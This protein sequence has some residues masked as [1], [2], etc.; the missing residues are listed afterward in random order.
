MCYNTYFLFSVTIILQTGGGAGGENGAKNEWNAGWMK[1]AGT[2]GTE[3]VFL[4]PGGWI[5]PAY[6]VP[7]TYCVQVPQ[8]LAKNN[9]RG[10]IV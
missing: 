4:C 1:V 5:Y 10:G 6:R 3:K 8:L 2:D 7:A 9:R